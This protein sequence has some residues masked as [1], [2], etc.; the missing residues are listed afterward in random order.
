MRRSGRRGRWRA[1]ASISAG[2]PV[3]MN[4][5]D[6]FA[7]RRDRCFDPRR[8]DRVISRIDIDQNRRRPGRQHRRNRRHRGVR[9]R[10]DFIARTDAERAQGQ[11][12]RV[13]PAADADARS[14]RRNSPQRHARR[15]R[16]LRR[17]HRCRLQN[18]RD[19]GLDRRRGARDI[20]PTA[21]PRE[22]WGTRQ[23][24]FDFHF[25]YV[26]EPPPARG[27]EC[28]FLFADFGSVVP[29]KQ[30]GAIGIALRTNSA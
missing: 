25:G 28:L 6:C 2:L 10:D 30:Q 23:S 13:G 14:L 21:R 22:S 4:R 3:D 7:A 15:T 19:R 20:A 8:I 29:G 12:Q 24:R 11:D 27:N 9:H 17:G 16:P 5:N 18:A 1:M 26:D